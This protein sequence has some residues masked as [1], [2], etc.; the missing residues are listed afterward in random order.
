LSAVAYPSQIK[1]KIRSFYI[2]YLLQNGVGYGVIYE[3]SQFW[4]NMVNSRS[5]KSNMGKKLLTITAIRQIINLR[6]DKNPNHILMEIAVAIQ[7][8]FGIEVLM[9][10]V[11]KAYYKHKDTL[12]AQPGKLSKIKID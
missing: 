10:A 11:R 12:P 2:P 6:S 5:W 3:N 7:N 1:V 4:S 9:D 8:E